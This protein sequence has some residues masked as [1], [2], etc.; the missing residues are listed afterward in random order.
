MP[1]QAHMNAGLGMAM[2]ALLMHEGIAMMADL[3]I[4]ALLI[5]PNARGMRAIQV[6]GGQR[7]WPAVGPTQPMLHSRQ[8]TSA[9]FFVNSGPLPT[10]VRAM[11]RL[12]DWRPPTASSMTGVSSPRITN[13]GSIKRGY[14]TGTLQASSRPHPT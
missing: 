14:G 9:D 7:G 12:N 4:K 6:S 1:H 10:V 5:D 2:A 11:L 8:I 3:S 13:F